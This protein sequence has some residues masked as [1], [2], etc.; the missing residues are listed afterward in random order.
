[1]SVLADNTDHGNNDHTVHPQPPPLVA[2]AMSGPATACSCGIDTATGPAGPI[3]VLRVAGEID[4]L[5]RSLVRTAL[6]A[7]LDQT[8]HDL[9]VDVAGVG[10]C[11]V[12]GFELLADT[13]HAARAAGIGF[14]LS[15]LSRHLDRVL[16]LLWPEDQFVRYRSVAAAV[17]AIRIDHTHRLS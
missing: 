16:G 9:L 3:L 12:R 8:P 5:T 10:F 15:G 6:D 13:A 7:A 11:C 4:L 2:G 17:T 14:A 1:M